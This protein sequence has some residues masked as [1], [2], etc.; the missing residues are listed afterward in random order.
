MRKCRLTRD[1]F[2]GDDEGK[3][4]EGSGARECVTAL[5]VVVRCA[6]DP[7]PV[8]VHDVIV[9]QEE[10]GARISDSVDRSA[11]ASAA[12][13]RVAVRSE[14]PETLTAVHRDIYD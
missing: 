6:V 10:R 5:V 13:N 3:G 9:E 8:V 11:A 1:G 7:A 2:T 12:T 4:R 14:L